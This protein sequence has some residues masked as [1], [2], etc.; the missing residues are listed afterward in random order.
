MWPLCGSRH[1]LLSIPCI[2]SRFIYTQMSRNPIS[3]KQRLAALAAGPSAASPP[4]GHD[5]SQRPTG[6]RRRSIINVPWAR[7]HGHSE[8][9]TG[10][11]FQR[12]RL[13]EVMGKMIYQAG[14]DFE[15]VPSQRCLRVNMMFMTLRA[16]PV[17]HGQCT[18]V[19]CTAATTIGLTRACQSRVVL[20]ASALP[21]PREVSYDLLLT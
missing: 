4:H 3:L 14:V 13:Q 9:L 10:T 11:E 19:N 1:H 16:L 5:R 18:P 20:N 21:D 6:A 17:G 12:D 8:S 2:T 7:R 15:C